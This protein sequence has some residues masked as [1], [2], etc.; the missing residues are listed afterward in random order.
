M[1]EIILEEVKFVVFKKGLSWEFV[2][3]ITVLGRKLSQFLPK[4][5]VWN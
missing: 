3:K 5:Y 1:I 2:I 4:D